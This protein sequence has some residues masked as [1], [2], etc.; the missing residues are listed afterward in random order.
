MSIQDI[1]K[2]YGINN[3]TIN[4]D[5][6]IDVASSVYINGWDLYEIPLNFNKVDGLFYCDSN[7]LTSL[8]GCPNWVG[9]DFTCDNNELTNLEFGPKYVGGNFWCNNNKLTSL[10]F[11]PEFIGKD[12]DCT[13]NELTDLKGS[14]EKI[15][16]KFDCS[17]NKLTDLKG[18]PKEVD[19]YFGCR[20]NE[21]TS[22]LGCPK[23][24]ND[25]FDCRDN[26]LYDIDFIPE[27][28]RLDF[29]SHMNPIGELCNNV[30]IDFL[31]A[32]K[33]YKII[34]DNLVNLKRLKYLMS[35]FDKSIYI[36]G[37]EK[38]YTIS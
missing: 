8:K 29:V 31:R 17:W 11:S 2:T 19:G 9:D 14:P 13:D 24:I 28:I 27:F 21:L 10:E 33:S 12:Y 1:C 32:F 25:R 15:N 26:K 4:D 20:T 23:S 34:K 36:E 3:Y 7:K 37:I 30:D 6:S 35:Q 16:G 5:G 22:L 18:S 38:Y